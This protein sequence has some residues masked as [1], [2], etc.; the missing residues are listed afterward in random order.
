MRPFLTCGRFIVREHEPSGGAVVDAVDR[1][2]PFACQQTPAGVLE[3]EPA[4]EP[5]TTGTDADA[6]RW[7]CTP[8]NDPVL[9]AGDACRIY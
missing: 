7:A 3:A 9:H 4:T 2:R 8:P 5:P 6:L 1:S